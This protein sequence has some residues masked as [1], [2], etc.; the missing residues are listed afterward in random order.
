MSE[1]SRRV[2][3]VRDIT[4]L[5]SAVQKHPWTAVGIGF[6]VG[7]LFAVTR[8]PR[9]RP[10]G[11][12]FLASSIRTMLVSVAATY[13]RKLAQ[14]WMEEQLHRR[15]DVLARDDV[16]A[17]AHTVSGSRPRETH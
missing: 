17:P 7:L 13:G 9:E 8:P 15:D 10:R 12:G 16:R 1:L 14:Q 3:R 11:D 4:D 5:T 6:A 2:D